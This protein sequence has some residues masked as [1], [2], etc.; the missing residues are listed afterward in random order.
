MDTLKDKK[1][2]TDMWLKNQAPWA[3]WMEGNKN[4]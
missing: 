1:D 4:V 2:L 3:I